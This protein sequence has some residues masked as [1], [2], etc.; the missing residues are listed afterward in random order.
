MLVFGLS[1]INLAIFLELKKVEEEN[2]YK[3]AYYHYIIYQHNPNH[4]AEDYVVINP[5]YGKFY[6]IYAF[7]DPLNPLKMVKVGIKENYFN[8]KINKFMSKLLV[9]EFL[10]ILTLILLYQTVIEGYTKRLKE[11]EDWIKN[12]MLSL[13]HRLGNF[14]ATQRVAISLLIK[15]YPQDKNIRRMEKS[16]LRMQ[17][18]FSIFTNLIRENRN[19]E[20]RSYNLRDFILDSLNYFE[21]ELKNKKTYLS[22]KDMRVYIDKTDLEDILYN[23]LGNAIKHSKSFLHIKICPKKKLLIVRND[24]SNISKSGMGMGSQLIKRVLDSYG[25]KVKVRIKKDYTVFVHFSTK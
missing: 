25:Y 13:T 9:I 14:I 20:K 16:I 8:E 23:L 10:L 19:I 2:L 1:L 15:N 12:L 17:R 21:E 4:K 11:K 22:L 3:I 7:E 18:D 6:R 5:T 24:T